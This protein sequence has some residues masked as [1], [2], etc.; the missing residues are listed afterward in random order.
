M[1]SLGQLVA[2]IAHEI[3]NPVNFI[4]GNLAHTDEYTKDLLNLLK[5]YQHHYSH[6]VP[7]IQDEMAAIDLDFL[8]GDLPKMLTSMKVGAERIRQI[9]LSLR[10]FSRLDEAEMKAVDIHEGIE[11]SLLILQNRL[12]T[13]PDHPG[14][15]L[16][17]EYGD[18]PQVE[19]YA[20]Q[21]NQVF[22]NLLTNAI[23][24]LEERMERGE[25]NTKS[26]I[27]KICIRTSV[28][29]SDRVLIS[30]ADN[31]LGMTEA[32]KKQLFNPFFTTKPVGKGTGLG[33]SI[34]YQ[35]V[36]EKHGGQLHC[37]S[38]PGQGTEFAI[39]IP[40]QQHS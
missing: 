32:M 24:A 25:E 8:I 15:Q 18:L 2:G 30:I 33:L 29:N 11:S 40:I 1:S 5:L 31:G 12:K 36:V 13:K 37:L 17:K 23:D 35:I 16:I 39:A 19:C 38:E 9:V 26:Y 7:E 14:I 34:S 27:P 28:V 21:L 4:Y 3:N 20:G 22:M 6:P 10:N